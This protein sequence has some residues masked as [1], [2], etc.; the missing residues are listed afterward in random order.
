M[1]S[2][3]F[4]AA[5][6]RSNNRPPEG[7]TRGQRNGRNWRA[8]NYDGV[9]LGESVIVRRGHDRWFFCKCK[10]AGHEFMTG[11]NVIQSR[12]QSGKPLACKVCK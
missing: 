11:L 12:I 9:D 7:A 5:D 8:E 2:S 6:R 3:E 1:P 4:N 10:A